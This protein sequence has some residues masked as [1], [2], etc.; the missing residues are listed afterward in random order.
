MSH[1]ISV[2]QMK[3]LLVFFMT[4]D[5]LWFLPNTLALQARQ[6]AWFVTIV[7][8]LLGYAA[9]I[10]LYKFW[11]RLGGK[12]YVEI[13]LQTLG[14]VAGGLVLLYFFVYLL[15]NTCAEARY[16][17]DFM[18]I[19]ILTETPL[20]V[21]LLLFTAVVMIAVR[22]GLTVMARSGQMFLVMFLVLF[23]VLSLLLLP[24]MEP[25]NLKPYLG[26]G[27]SHLAL[28]TLFAFVYPFFQLIV[29]FMV[30]PYVVREN[31]TDSEYERT[32]FR[33]VF[34]GSVITFI[35]VLLSILVLGA[36]MTSHNQFSTYTMAKK[37]NIGDFV[38]RM[39]ALLII[40]YVWSTFFKCAITMFALCNGMKQWLRLNDDKMLI[41]P[42][43]S[44][45]YGISCYL[46]DNVVH[47]NS[48]GGAWLVWDVANMIL[49]VGLVY[50]VHVFRT[51][52]KSKKQ[53]SLGG[54]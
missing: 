25:S 36:H 48:L 49:F 5:M 39:E 44:M 33:S 50:A 52:L 4:G 43:F 35:V 53:R 47:Y 6:D 46:Y 1:Y 14:P 2:K 41:T 17:G 28:G 19:Q 20:N 27:I 37:I 10:G 7:G 45:L 18:S 26:S 42:V 9:A 34:A 31:L 30:L 23:V 51:Q 32:L 29:L 54:R 8:S 40:G 11:K 16:I 12:T 24:Q 15:L 13:V 21:I 22:T 38:Q 3:V